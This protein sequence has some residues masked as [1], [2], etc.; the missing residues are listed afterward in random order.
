MRTKR[1]ILNSI[2]SKIASGGAE[3]E[4]DDTAGKKGRSYFSP[5]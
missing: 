5:G 4:E 1:E 2:G 3:K